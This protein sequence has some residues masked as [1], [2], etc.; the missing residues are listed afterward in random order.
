MRIAVEGCSHG[1]LDTIYNVIQRLEQLHSFKVDLLLCCG[2][3]QSVRNEQDLKCMACPI[4]YMSMHDFHRY[5]SGEKKAP[6]LTIFI[7]GNHEAS[8]YLQELPYGG[9]VAPNIYYLG[10][11]GVVRYGGLRIG[12]LSGIYKGP[13]YLKGH[14]E[15][16][17]YNNSS[18]RSVY[19]VRNLEVFR[20][21][22]VRSMLPRKGLPLSGDHDIF[23]TH[24]WPRGIYHH[25]P[26]ARL[27]RQKKHFRDEIES[28]TLGSRAAEE[29]LKK[30]R[31]KYWFSG[32]LHV[33]FPAV[34]KHKELDCA[35][36]MVC[37]AVWGRWQGCHT[38]GRSD[39]SAAPD[40]NTQTIKVTKFLALDKCLPRRDFLQV[41][42]VPS[43][44]PLELSYDAEWLTILR[45]TNH[46]LSVSDKTVYMPGPGSSERYQFTP[47]QEEIAETVRSMDGNLRIP[48]NFAPTVDSYKEARGKPRMDL[49]QMPQPQLNPQTTALCERLC[50][51]DPLSLLQG[52]KQ[53][54]AAAAAASASASPRVGFV[55]SSSS[56]NDSELNIT[57]ET[58]KLSTNPDEV[59]YSP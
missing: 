3:F 11:A 1:E 52:N 49:V 15:K 46:L 10:Y 26:K 38:P 36:F 47:S 9:W 44:D 51:D 28:N 18:I 14:Y 53:R 23:M 45:L 59:R 37:V 33:R 19:H 4:K 40:E 2:D 56:I 57:M 6:V 32:H 54:P 22:Q 16:T 24:D 27:M 29:L 31:P 50:V 35:L 48:L 39:S 8:N 21:K 43:P 55:T 5:H 25:G 34:L 58:S 20:L 30:L 17:P 42:E 41:I 13:D 12:G 7:G